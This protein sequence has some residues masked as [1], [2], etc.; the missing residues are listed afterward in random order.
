MAVRTAACNCRSLWSDARPG[1]VRL[2]VPEGSRRSILFDRIECTVADPSR[3]PNDRT[4]ARL[5]GASAQK[6]VVTG[7]GADEEP[8]FHPDLVSLLAHQLATPVSTIITLAQ[9]LSRRADNLDVQNVRDRAE[10]I[11]QAGLRLLALIESIMD[12][13]RAD[14]GAIKY[15]PRPFDPRAIALRVCQEQRTRH[16]NRPFAFDLDDLPTVMDGDPALLEQVVDILLGNAIKYSSPDRPIAVRAHRRGGT[17]KVSI[18]DQGMGIPSEDLQHLA[19]P[20]FRG[21]NARSV[22]G[23]GLGLSLARHILGLHGGRLE[24][25]SREGVG[26]TIS[27]VVPMAHEVGLG[28]GI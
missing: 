21:Q 3:V 5:S 19:K 25:E 26:S 6:P 8:L 2:T 23:T 27:M 9:S 17:I 1:L 7:R 18:Q 20:F 28:E 13:A 22:P 15:T 14:A 11:R 12:R 10:R 24:I 4:I 16:P